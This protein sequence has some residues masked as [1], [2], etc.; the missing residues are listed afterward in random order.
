M[1]VAKKILTSHWHFVIRALSFETSVNHGKWDTSQ[2]GNEEA[3]SI[4]GTP[5]E[6]H[7]AGALPPSM[8][9]DV[10]GQL[11]GAV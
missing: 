7:H 6:T 10:L 4:D 8:L 2:A 1:C 11:E 5:S 3:Q 9:N